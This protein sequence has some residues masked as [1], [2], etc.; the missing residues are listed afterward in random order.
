MLLTDLQEVEAICG[1]HGKRS[2]HHFCAVSLSFQHL[3]ALLESGRLIAEAFSI[4]SACQSRVSGDTVP[5]SLELIFPDES[6]FSQK[7]W[8]RFLFKLL[9]QLTLCFF[10]GL[11]YL[12]LVLNIQYSIFAFVF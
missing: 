7:N 8:G 10:H 1:K 2:E 12:G 6:R 5:T 4:S 3:V 9:L 11:S